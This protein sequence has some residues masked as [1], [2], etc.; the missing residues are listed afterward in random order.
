MTLPEL[1]KVVADLKRKVE[2]L[3][4]KQGNSTN[5]QTDFQGR[6]VI[7]RKVQYMDTVYDKNGVVVTEINP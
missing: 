6:Q 5:M 7:R 4:R 1:E 3:E 2:D